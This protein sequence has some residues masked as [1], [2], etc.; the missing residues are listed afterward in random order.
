[1]KFANVFNVIYFH[2][3]FTILW[4]FLTYVTISVYL[5]TCIRLY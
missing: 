4:G 3:V 5:G 2:V 1:M